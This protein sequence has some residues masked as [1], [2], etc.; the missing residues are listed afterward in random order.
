M[1]RVTFT[2]AVASVLQYVSGDIVAG[3]IC[4]HV[5]MSCQS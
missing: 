2:I 3:H 4:F 5:E 1:M